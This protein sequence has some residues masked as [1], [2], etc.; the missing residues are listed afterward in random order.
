[1]ATYNFA[2]ITAEEA[3]AFTA[4]DVLEFSDLSA[5]EI[6]VQPIVGGTQFIVEGRIVEIPLSA[7]TIAG[8]NT[9]WVQF[10]DG[11]RL[12]VGDGSGNSTLADIGN[13]IDL[14]ASGGGTAA[15]Y[16]GL[17]GA[18]NVT[19]TANADL[20]YGNVAGDTVTAG[21]GAD[22]VY[23]GQDADSIIGGAGADVLYGN[24]AADT[25]EG[26][27]GNDTLF[28]GQDNDLLVGGA[29]ND[30]LWG[31]LGDDSIDSTDASADVVYGNQGADTLNASAADTIYGGQDGDTLLMGGAALAYGNMGADTITG[32]AGVDTVYGGQD[33]DSITGAGGADVLY[34]NL[35]ADTL[36]GGAAADILSGDGGDDVFAVTTTGDETNDTII[37]G[38]GTDTLLVDATG[39]AV[40][41]TF[42]NAVVG[43]EAARVLIGDLD[44]EGATVSFA[45]VE[46]ALSITIDEQDAG[47][48]GDA[49]VTGTSGGDRIV[50]NATL[51]ADTILGGGG[52][53]TIDAGAGADSIIGGAGDDVINLGSDAVADTVVGGANLGVDTV[54]S[55][56]VNGDLINLGAVPAAVAQADSTNVTTGALATNDVVALQSGAAT[57]LWLVTAA[58]GVTAGTTVSAAATA[59][60]IEKIMVLT[61]VTNDDITTADFV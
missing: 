57:E 36:N 45:N 14:S 7:A 23:G 44:T 41:A 18:D 13:T 50:S 35:G 59:G 51:S 9:G 37:G 6:R 28:G 38:E 33:A 20:I 30:E 47:D 15:Q 11:T 52:A 32:S 58:G 53:D 12:V 25:L 5:N 10:T 21:D 27:D 8:D 49:Q 4:S 3:A 42:G 39:G 17:G 1:M 22:T 46:S 48:L 34:G 19:G 26:G 40:D 60:S 2:S 56:D 24:L 55:F 43:V 31:N 61:G 54:S 16:W 29:G